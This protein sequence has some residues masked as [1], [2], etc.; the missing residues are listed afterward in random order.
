MTLFEIH[1]RCCHD[2]SSCGGYVDRISQHDASKWIGSPTLYCGVVDAECLI[3]WRRR[4]AGATN[5]CFPFEI[6]RHRSFGSV[7]GEKSLP[8]RLDT[9]LP[10]TRRTRRLPGPSRDAILGR[11]SPG[12]RTG[13]PQA[14]TAGPQQV[15]STARWSRNQTQIQRLKPAVR[16]D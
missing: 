1:S 2:G 8:F 12:A 5:L 3:W 16:K 11:L 9:N 10:A 7:R 6:V 14:G 4:D 15:D 13:P